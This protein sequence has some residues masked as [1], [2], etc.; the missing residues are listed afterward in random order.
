MGK[1]YGDNDDDYKD[2]AYIFS[3]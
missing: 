3:Y 2:I 1:V